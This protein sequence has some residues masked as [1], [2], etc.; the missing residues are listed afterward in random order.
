MRRERRRI[1]TWL[2]FRDTDLP[3]FP[4]HNARTG[5]RSI[6]DYIQ[7]RENLANIFILIDARHDPQQ[8]DI[9]FVNK[10]GEWRVPF[11]IVFTKADKETQKV[12]HQNADNFLQKLKE[13]WAELPPHFTLTSAVK[14]TGRT[15][16]LG[17]IGDILS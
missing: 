11:A 14:K 15:K 7:K 6:K 8:I 5:R 17:F 13:S 10:L 2:T 16:L 12:V 1:G 4:R 3:R 9:D